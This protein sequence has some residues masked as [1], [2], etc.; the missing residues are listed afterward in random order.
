MRS[1]R[2]CL[3]PAALLLVA[4]SATNAARA[5]GDV[6]IYRCVA[7]GGKI[8]L[9]DH[10]CPK[11][12]HQDVR[13]MIRPQDPPPRPAAPVLEAPPAPAPTEVRIVHVRDPQPL[14]E[15]RSYDGQTYLSQTGIPQVHLVP[16]WV[17][18]FRMFGGSGFADVGRP[19]PVIATRHSGHP[20][21]G[22]FADSTGTWIE[23]RCV[24]LPQAEVCQ[25]M[26]DRQ[27]ELGTRIFN[28]Q[29]SDRARFERE[30][31]GLIEQLREDCN[32]Y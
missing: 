18:G 3:L 28:A 8:S 4:L 23:D 11:D 31:Q 30:R 32:A 6:T 22:Q 19:A 12:A 13:E 1:V 16:L 10:P 25:R 21:N 24:R 17:L 26:R 7:T 15:C 9:Q 2:F 20:P 14:Y 29:P 5:A 27:D